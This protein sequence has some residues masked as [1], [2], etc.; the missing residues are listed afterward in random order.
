MYSIPTLLGITLD[1]YLLSVMLDIY[2][3]FN[4]DTKKYLGIALVLTPYFN[5]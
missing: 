1:K 2:L 5:V 4:D 3:Q